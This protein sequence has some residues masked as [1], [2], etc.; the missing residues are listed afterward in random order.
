MVK[1]TKTKATPKTKVSASAATSFL[2]NA[3]TVHAIA[4]VPYLIGAIA[5]YFLGKSDKKAAMHHIIYSAILAVVAIVLWLLLLW[6]FLGVFIGPVYIIGSFYLA[7][8]AYNGEDVTVEILDTI[9]GKIT[10]KIK[11]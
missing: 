4:Y 6:S 10:E 5:M 2:E 8:K 1:E 7:W 11:K 9:E 3:N